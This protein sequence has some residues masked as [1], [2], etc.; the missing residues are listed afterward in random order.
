MLIHLEKQKLTTGQLISRNIIENISDDEKKVIK[1]IT[2]WQDNTPFFELTTSGSTG[3][4]TAIQL[5]R[6]QIQYSAR[7][8]LAF[9]DPS[10]SFKSTLLCINPDFIGGLMVIIRSLIQ[11]MD[12]T[13]IPASSSFEHLPI[14][15]TFDLS[16]MVPLQLQ[17]L[18]DQQSDKLNQFRTILIGGAPLSASYIADLANFPHLQVYQTYGMTET[19]SHIALKNLS[20]QETTYRTLGDVQ[21][22]IDDR[23]CLKLMGTITNNQWIQTNDVVHIISDSEFEWLGRADFTINSAGIK[24]HPEILEEQLSS[25]IKFPFFVAGID[26]DKLG[27]KAILLIESENEVSMD[28]SAIDRY[29]RPKEVHYLNQFRYT[30]SGKINRKETLELIKNP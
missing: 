28:F 25:Q 11:G 19:A 1:V 27:Q 24:I 18:I 29:K 30:Q 21:I 10:R 12:L 14:D 13:V 15:K 17:S 20:E 2:A 4:P 16:S 8:S 7:S 6:D 23:Q 26:D 9:L 5:H 3:Q 22:D